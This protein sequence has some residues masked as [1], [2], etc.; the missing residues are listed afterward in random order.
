MNWTLINGEA[1][2]AEFPDTWGLLPLEERTSVPVGTSV[3]LGFEFAEG[4]ER[5]WVAVTGRTESGG[6]LGDLKNLPF[7]DLAGLELGSP[8]SFGPEH[9]LDIW[10]EA[11][12]EYLKSLGPCE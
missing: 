8:V 11:H 10:S 9:I 7:F 2:H 12:E 4:G 3:K 5:M 6:Y 1:R